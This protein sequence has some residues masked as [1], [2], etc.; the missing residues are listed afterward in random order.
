MEKDN[1]K[2]RFFWPLMKETVT[3]EDRRRV[4]EFVLSAEW[5][6]SGPKVGEFEKAWNEWLGCAHSLFVSS[7]SAANLLLLA[8]AME[9]Y[10]I[11]PG[12]KVA[13]PAVTWSTH[14]T[15]IIQMGLTP[16][17]CDVNPRNFAIDPGHLRK[18]SGQNPDMNI[19]FAAH[20]L[21]IPAPVKRYREILPDAVF[22]EDACE[23]HGAQTPHG[24]VGSL[25][26]GGTFSFYFGHHMTTLEGGMVCV[27]D[28]DLYE[29]MRAKRSHGQAREHG[30]RWFEHFKSQYPDVDERFL[31]S[32]DGFNFRNTEVGAVLGLSQLERLDAMIARRRE[33]LDRFVNMTWIKYPDVFQSFQTE[34][35]SSFC[36][37]FICKERAMTASLRKFLY[38]KGIESRPFCGGNLMRQPFLSGKF[39]AP[40]DFPNA[41]YLHFHGF[42]IGNN[43]LVKDDEIEVLENLLEE[44]L[45]RSMRCK[46]GAKRVEP[47]LPAG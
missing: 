6:T 31:F 18:I 3:V 14:I 45:G 37:P 12:T 15:P 25:F 36:L 28:G 35:N 24:K 44:F 33:V 8:G 4:A 41:D 23:S 10:G 5:L 32:T 17:F 46:E 42:Y 7:G 19:I 11:K 16:V 26:S 27:K 20:L 1:P 34:G 39:G 30:K 21:G 2:G 13:V 29:I 47:G 40:E 38:G 43:H 22:L 9:R